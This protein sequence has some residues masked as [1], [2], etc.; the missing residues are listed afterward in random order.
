MRDNPV[1]PDNLEIYK[2]I[3]IFI[4]ESRPCHNIS[5]DIEKTLM[6][7]YIW[8]NLEVSKLTMI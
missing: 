3:L 4:R 2:I 5:G 1:K 7:R 8:E 6:I